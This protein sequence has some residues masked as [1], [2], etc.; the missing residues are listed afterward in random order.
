MAKRG[1]R[2]TGKA[3]V[4]KRELFRV[5]GMDKIL[6]EI[7]KAMDRVTAER[8][9]E[10]FV[11][12]AIPI[13]SSVKENIASLDAST[14][15]KQMLDA[16]MM[17]NQG[18]P[19]RANV[20]TGMSQEYAR[21]VKP[22]L[23]RREAG[24]RILSPYWVEF[25]TQPRYTKKKHFKYGWFR[26]YLSPKPFFRPAVEANKGKV[27]EVLVSELRRVIEDVGK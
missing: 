9:K 5:E 1:R 24:W 4:T 2:G 19:K 25:G 13:W 16:M 7:T 18:K 20:L 23:F 17:I 14:K 8:L 15:I 26:G 6:A 12:A 11:K 3:L 27:K 10:V 21:R 22:N